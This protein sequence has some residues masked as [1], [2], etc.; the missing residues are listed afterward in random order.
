MK[1]IVLAGGSGTRLAPLTSIVCKQLLPIYDKP[2]LYYPISVLMMAGIKDILIISTPKDL[3]MME[4]L[5]GS[6]AQM[7]VNFSYIEQAEPK[8]IAQALVLAQDFTGDDSCCLIL[9][10][11]LFYGHKLVEQIAAAGKHDHGATVF[12]YRVVDPERYGVVEFDGAGKA[13][14]IEEKPKHPRSHWAVTGLYVYDN[15]A[16]GLARALR[17]SARGE[18]EITDLNNAYL[19]DGSLRVEILGRGTAWLDTGTA[20]SLLSASQFVQVIEA[21]QGQKIACLEEIAY[22]KEWI[23]SE[24]LFALA[25]AHGKNEYGNYLR[26]LL[27]DNA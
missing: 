3:P 18:L 9:G 2:M 4:S 11:N 26:H 25:D 10:D 19:Y 8:G 27:D 23:D 12:A 15:R 6:G 1:G 5:L 22:R 14:S 17:P 20:D 7:G 21:R 16:A 24:Q 13:I